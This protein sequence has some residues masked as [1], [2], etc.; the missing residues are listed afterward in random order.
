[1]KTLALGSP[2]PQSPAALLA[3]TAPACLKKGQDCTRQISPASPGAQQALHTVSWH[4]T[5]GLPQMGT[6]LPVRTGGKAEAPR[7]LR[8]CVQVGST[9]GPGRTSDWWVQKSCGALVSCWPPEAPAVGRIY[10]TEM[11]KYYKLGFRLVLVFES[12]LSSTP[13]A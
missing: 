2:T 11:G 1:M 8:K 9:P 5:A 13:L 4:M 6:F 12:W 7:E 10:T 3:P